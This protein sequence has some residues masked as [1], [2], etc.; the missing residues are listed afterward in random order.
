MPALYAIPEFIREVNVTMGYPLGSSSVYS[1]VD[2]LYQLTRNSRKDSSGNTSWYFRDV[3][4]LISNPVVKSWYGELS[5]H[6]RQ[7]ALT[8][9]KVYLTVSDIRTDGVDDVIFNNN[10]RANI[11]DYLLDAITV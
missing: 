2:T 3:L 11:C 9:H 7:N 8:H 4:T 5:D 6:V 10:E 1:L